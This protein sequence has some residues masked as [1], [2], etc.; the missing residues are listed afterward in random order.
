M[1][2]Q[3]KSDLNKPLS[4]HS[5]PS[6]QHE[7][8]STP[9]PPTAIPTLPTMAME[10][11][12][13]HP[14]PPHGHHPIIMHPLP[15]QHRI[16]IQINTNGQQFIIPQHPTIIHHPPHPQHRAPPDPNQSSKNLPSHSHNG[17]PPQRLFS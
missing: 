12:Q 8:G 16:P 11:S 10:P 4:S 17:P 6:P 2:E 15:P 9:N 5:N 14:A 3:S 7:Q 13:G 1:S